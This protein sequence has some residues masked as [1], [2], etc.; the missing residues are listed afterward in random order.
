VND[1][2]D[3]SDDWMHPKTSTSYSY[4]QPENK[5]E[6]RIMRKRAIPVSGNVACIYRWDVWATFDS[7]GERDKEYLR[8]KRSHP[9]WQVMMDEGNPHYE[10]FGIK[11][12]DE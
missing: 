9:S 11:G 5:T 8:L 7:R 12:E 2:V 10:I 4:K 3:Y 1:D 6:Y